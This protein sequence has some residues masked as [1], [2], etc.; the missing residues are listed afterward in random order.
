MVQAESFARRPA[1]PEE[2]AKETSLPFTRA[3]I[4]QIAQEYPTPFFIY[5]EEGIRQNAKDFRDAFSWAPNFRNF[6]AVKALPNPHILAILQEEGFGADCSSMAELVIAERVGLSGK[7]IMFTSNNTPTKEFIKADELGAIINLDDITHLSYLEETVELPDTLCFRFN[8][9]P[10]KEG[11]SIIGKPEEAKYGLK[12]DQLFE[13][14][15]LAKEKGVK[16]FGLHTMVASN[17]R[18]PE[19]FAETARMLFRLVGELHDEL[20]IEI[21]FINL[22]GGVGIPY[23]PEHMR[24]DIRQVSS[25]IEK[26]YK[27][28]IVDKGLNPLQIT[29]ECG[30]FVTGPYGYYVAKA[31][32]VTEKYRDYVGLDGSTTSMPRVAIYDTAYHHATVLGKEGAPREMVYDVTGSLCE[33]N[34]KFARQ[35]A[36][37]EIHPDDLVVIHDAGAHGIAMANEY[38]G[39]LIPRELLLKPDGSVL[40]I[41]RPR[42]IDDYFSTIEN[43]PGF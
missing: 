21:S 20:G 42:T 19:Y 34:D 6:F 14:Y 13:A 39:Q 15:K 30:R 33:N 35:R 3:Q 38:N 7:E 17:E 2:V 27:T 8:P 4:E 22:G 12:K 28:M 25:Q 24:V 1:T 10:L 26:D 41:R 9:G 36:M 40:Q 32:H 11:N 18:D 31:R 23:R 16:R 29:M 37:P 5:D 43:Y